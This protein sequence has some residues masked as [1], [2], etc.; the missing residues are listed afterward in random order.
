MMGKKC[1]FPGLGVHGK[2]GLKNTGMTGAYFF[3]IAT[4]SLIKCLALRFIVS[5]NVTTFAYVNV[6]IIT[7]T[8]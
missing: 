7:Y 3:G 8:V 5:Q 2:S 1:I 4:F 6:T